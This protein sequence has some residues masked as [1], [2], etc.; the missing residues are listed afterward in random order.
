MT[1]YLR[2]VIIDKEVGPTVEDNS[3]QPAR[4]K[5]IDTAS[6]TSNLISRVLTFD[7][8]LYET[9]NYLLIITA[10]SVTKIKKVR[11]KVRVSL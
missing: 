4:H 7:L 2:S 8:R 1:S 10:L 9:L 6:L 11:I 3:Y 5:Y